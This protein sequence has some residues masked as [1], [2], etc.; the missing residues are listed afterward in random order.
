MRARVARRSPRAS[1]AEPS[2][3]STP[4]GWPVGTTPAT[5][6]ALKPEELA[7]FVFDMNDWLIENMEVW[8]ESAFDDEKGRF[9]SRKTDFGS[10]HASATGVYIEGMID[11]YE[12][13]K[14]TGDKPRQARYALALSRAIRSVMQLQF[15][16]DVDMYYVTDRVQTKGGLRTTVIR[17]EVRVDNV[18]HVLMGMLKVIERFEPGEYK[19]D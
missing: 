3:Q 13:A 2:R 14:R 1:G 15:V 10:P 7:S 4:E 12:I 16:D 9:H 19:T 8:E 18:Q 17:P 11:A 6:V 5:P